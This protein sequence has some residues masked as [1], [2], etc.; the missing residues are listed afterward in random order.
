MKTL[1]P[2]IALFLAVA[3]PGVA[4]NAGDSLEQY[5]KQLES[6]PKS[7][8]AHYRIGEISFLNKNY[9]VAANAFRRA[10]SGDLEPSWTKAWSHI[11]LGKIFDVT[12][13]RERAILQY[14]E[15]ERTKDNTRDAQKE[16][17]RYLE[18]P[19]SESK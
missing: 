11:T 6:N 4:Q 12:G 2:A 18:S 14:K 10:L 16:V 9:Q 1:L 5:R 15:A 13:Q 7:S 8:L 3:V 19:Y 17:A